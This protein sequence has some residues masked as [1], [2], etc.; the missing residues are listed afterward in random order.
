MGGDTGNGRELGS[1]ILAVILGRL[2][3]SVGF[4]ALNILQRCQNYPPNARWLILSGKGM[5]AG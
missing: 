1:A 4:V 5:G 3:K 2:G